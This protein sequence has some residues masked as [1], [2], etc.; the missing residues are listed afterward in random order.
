MMEQEEHLATYY[1]F[2]ITRIKYSLTFTRIYL[3]TIAIYFYLD[4]EYLSAQF[5]FFPKL[6]SFAQNMST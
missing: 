2:Y 4:F 6:H 3:V 1:H 5:C